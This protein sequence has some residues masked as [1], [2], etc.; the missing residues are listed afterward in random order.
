MSVELCRIPDKLSVTKIPDRAHVV[1]HFRLNKSLSFDDVKTVTQVV[2]DYALTK[3]SPFLL[4]IQHV[5]EGDLEFPDM[6]GMLHISGRLLEHRDLLREL[7]MGTCIQAQRLGDVFMAAKG[8]FLNIYQPI[9]PFDVVV[10]DAD[11]LAFREKIVH[12]F[13]KR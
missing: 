13:T 2:V 3:E 10:G 4:Y 12:Q 7:L 8:L 1:L 11:S 5:G 9:A 6:G